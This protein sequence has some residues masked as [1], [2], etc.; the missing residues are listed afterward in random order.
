MPGQ[1]IILKLF[2]FLHFSI[3][4]ND[5]T[6]WKQKVPVATSLNNEYCQVFCYISKEDVLNEISEKTLN[7][8]PAEA[9]FGHFQKKLM[10]IILLA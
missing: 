4:K 5:V 6:H 9:F 8:H 3:P 1:V 7:D 10:V 2:K